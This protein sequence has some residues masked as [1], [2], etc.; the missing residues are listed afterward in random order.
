MVMGIGTRLRVFHLYVD[1]RAHRTLCSLFSSHLHAR[2]RPL[3][4][5]ARAA[6]TPRCGCYLTLV[7]TRVALY[8]HL[9]RLPAGFHCCDGS[10]TVTHYVYGCCPPTLR[11]RFAVGFAHTHRAHTTL[12]VTLL[13]AARY[14]LR[15]RSGGLWIVVGCTRIYIYV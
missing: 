2:V 13:V 11:S 12:P 3:P 14:A 1:T 5:C 4:G 7:T 9:L 15:T 8:T 6:P 10:V